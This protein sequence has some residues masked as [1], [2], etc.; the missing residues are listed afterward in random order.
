MV[1]KVKRGHKCAPSSNRIGSLRRG[2]D[3]SNAH[4]ENV[5]TPQEGSHLHA[6]SCQ[7]IHLGLLACRTGGHKF[8]LFRQTILWA[9]C[10]GNPSRLI[11]CLCN[12]ILRILDVSVGLAPSKC[13]SI[14]P[15][16]SSRISIIGLVIDAFV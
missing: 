5:R 13:Y 3:T 6:M 8:L 2:R 7:H 1:S 14:L 4:T 16:I 12:I 15:N 11:Q 10:Y 9:F